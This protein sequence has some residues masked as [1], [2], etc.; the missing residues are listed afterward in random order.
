LIPPNSQSSATKTTAED[1]TVSV[2]PPYHPK[3]Y[4]EPENKVSTTPKAAVAATAAHRWTLVAALAPT[5]AKAVPVIARGSTNGQATRV[6]ALVSRPWMTTGR[7]PSTIKR[8]GDATV[9]GEGVFN[10]TG[11]GQTR[12]ITSARG[13]SQ[14]FVIKAWNDGTG[15]DTFLLQGT[16]STTGFTVQYLTSNAPTGVAQNWTTTSSCPQWAATPASR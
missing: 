4:R 11:A 9:L 7:C 5:M 10:T 6:M 13:V 1:T 8:T 2:R 15:A 12:A 3:L 16:G 14:T